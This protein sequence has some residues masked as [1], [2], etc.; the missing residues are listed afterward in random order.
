MAAFFGETHMVDYN[1]ERITDAYGRVQFCPACGAR[2]TVS[3][4]MDN[5]SYDPA[6]GRQ[7]G[8]FY[9][10]CSAAGPIVVTKK[11]RLLG[12]E[13]GGHQDI[14]LGRAFIEPTDSA[15]VHYTYPE[16]DYP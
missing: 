9:A 13:L 7:V 6:T 11:R 12:D 10:I 8:D 1:R 5:R 4:A 14:G 2:T 15:F 3:V 16:I